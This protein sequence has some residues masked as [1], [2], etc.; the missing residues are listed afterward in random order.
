MRERCGS[1][2][3]G[4]RRPFTCRDATVRACGA[5]AGASPQHNDS[6]ACQRRRGSALM[7]ETPHFRHPRVTATYFSLLPPQ[8]QR[9]PSAEPRADNSCALSPAGGTCGA[10]RSDYGH[11]L[12]APRCRTPAPPRSPAEQSAQRAE[13]AHGAEPSFATQG[14]GP[15]KAQRSRSGK[16]VQG[17]THRDPPAAPP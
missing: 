15:Q 7:F 2:R 8:W 9:C 6:V 17:T 3:A 14:D 1:R 12:R 13:A 11:P 10:R 4:S 16:A 5:A